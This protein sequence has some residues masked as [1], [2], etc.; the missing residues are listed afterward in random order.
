MRSGSFV[1][2]TKDKE[3]DAL[4]FVHNALG[5]DESTAREARDR[6]IARHT[7]RTRDRPKRGGRH[8]A[9]TRPGA[10]LRSRETVK[11]INQEGR[12]VRATERQKWLASDLSNDEPWRIPT[13]VSNKTVCNWFH[14]LGFHEAELKPGYPKTEESKAHIREYLKRLHKVFPTRLRPYMA[15]QDCVHR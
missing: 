10:T 15:V 3:C 1:L 9:M 14:A 13:R 12:Q 5:I 7:A 8:R 4:R 6:F 2:N 11:Q